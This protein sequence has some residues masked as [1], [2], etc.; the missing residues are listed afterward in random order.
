MLLG[1]VALSTVAAGAVAEGLATLE[2]RVT[3]RAV[4]PAEGGI[5][6][7]VVTLASPAGNRRILLA[8]AEVLAEAGFDVQVGDELRVRVFTGD[9]ADPLLTHTVLNVTRRTMV[10]LRT[11][12]GI[13]AWDANGAWRG[14]PGGP[15][16]GPGSGPGPHGPRGRGP[17]R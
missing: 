1:V 12:R 2:G 13:P 7:V 15:H 10:R 9:D 14:G 4:A 6:N 17:R 11:L 8:P 16:G 3:A 5:D